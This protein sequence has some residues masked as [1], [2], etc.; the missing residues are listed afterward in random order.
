MD[1]AEDAR[2][3]AQGSE[4]TGPIYIKSSLVL[5]LLWP[6][7]AHHVCEQSLYSFFC[8]TNNTLKLQDHYQGDTEDNDLSVYGARLD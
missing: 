2:D 3:V 4:S 5:L 6:G 8:R 7:C 1:S